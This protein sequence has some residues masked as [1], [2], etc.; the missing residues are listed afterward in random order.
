MGL[1]S[2]AA[3]TASASAV[4]NIPPP[5]EEE[6][7]EMDGS[8]DRT[9]I[10]SEGV[11]SPMGN[12]FKTAIG[13]SPFAKPDPG[14][15]PRPL[16]PAAPPP[17]N[18]QTQDGLT[19]ASVADETIVPRGDTGHDLAPIEA[20]GFRSIVDAPPEDTNPRRAAQSEDLNATIAPRRPRVVIGDAPVS[21]ATS[22]GMSPFS[23]DTGEFTDRSGEHP[24]D[25]GEHEPH[26]DDPQDEPP[27]DE[28]TDDD[29]QAEV[30]T[31]QRKALPMRDLPKAKP[32]P[33]A[34][35]GSSEGRRKVLM[36]AI[37]VMGLLTLVAIG[38]VIKFTAGSSTGLLFMPSPKMRFS[39][40]INPGKRVFNEAAK[41]VE[42]EPGDYTL[43][44]RPGDDGY[45][46]FKTTVSVHEGKL[47]AVPLAFKKKEAEPEPVPVP[48][49]VTPEPT[50]TP[51]PTKPEP[52][53]ATTWSVSFTS[54]E[55]GVEIVVDGKR[56]GVTPDAQLKDLAFG[57][58]VTGQAKKAGFEPLT[59]KVENP[60][61]LAQVEQ[62]L[63]LEREKKPEPKPEPRPEPRPVVVKPEPKPEPKPV[64]V[65]PEPK[66]EPKPVAVK[67][68][69]KPEPEPKPAPKAKGNGKLACTSQPIGADIFI[70]GK[71]TGKK[72]PLSKANAL[73]LPLGKHKITFKVGGKSQTMEFELT[74]ENKDNPAVVKGIVPDA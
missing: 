49:A 39:V 18:A 24:Q 30:P 1:Q 6:L 5:S 50:P 2:N 23:S 38:L 44:V 46:P 10:V 71:P 56:V 36:G 34:N 57:K 4:I 66:P 7:A 16:R 53:A 61:K 60:Q 51:T 22:I 33:A 11:A 25:T 21:G 12:D 52:A 40:T 73:E 54:S 68:E 64:A 8:R 72:T 74:E 15:A 3:P 67:P 31:G 48:V 27:E 58:V 14:P 29:V 65:K 37:G 20:T 63:Q 47:E 59:F 35:A 26:E 41:K 55:P 45:L 17:S 62:P 32:R 28:A 9:M 70:D 13:I 42:L 19:P 69:P 43:D